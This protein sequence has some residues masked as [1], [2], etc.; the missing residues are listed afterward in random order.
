MQNPLLAPWSGPFG[1]VPPFDETK[2]EHFKPALD[3]GMAAQLAEIERIANHPA[4]RLSRNTLA[5]LERSGR[6]LDR[7][8]RVYNVF[9]STMLSDA[10]QA[11]EREMEPKLAAFED[12]IIQNE[13]LFKRISAVYEARERSGLTPEQ[14][15][16]A[17]LK[18]TEFARSGA[19]LG[20]AAKGR[21]SAINQRLATL[22][23]E[24]SQNVLADES[25]LCAHRHRGRSGR[26]AGILPLRGR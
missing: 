17:W 2:V 13:K 6:A 20:A 15:R 3:E 1:G 14:Q 16:L 26:P 9:A 21:L 4:A 7:V 8:L 12:R 5:A 25:N 24:F 22:Y 19:Q 11:V 18:Y 10:F 23:T